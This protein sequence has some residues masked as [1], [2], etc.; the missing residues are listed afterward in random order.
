M[1]LVV[2]D[3]DRYTAAD[4]KRT[5]PFDNVGANRVTVDKLYLILYTAE[6][7]KATPTLTAKM[8]A[9]GTY[10]GASLNSD[11]STRFAID[12]SGG[13]PVVASGLMTYTINATKWG[14]SCCEGGTCATNKCN[15]ATVTLNAFMHTNLM[16]IAHST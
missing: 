14:G 13:T 15:I 3:L 2:S 7:L 9:H 11:M 12:A 5:F 10:A 4:D 6:T 1:W 8:P 16:L